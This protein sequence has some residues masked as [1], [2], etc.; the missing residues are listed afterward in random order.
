MRSR[1][2]AIVLAG[3]VW[4]AGA[5]Q[6][7][8]ASGDVGTAA[9]RVALT[10]EKP[11]AALFSIDEIVRFLEAAKQAEAI[12]DPL[13]RCLSYPDPPGSHWSPA[14]THAYCMYHMQEFMGFTEMK[15]LVEN[16]HAAELDRYMQNALQQQQTR[17]ESAGL[18]DHI[19]FGNFSDS[20]KETRALIDAWKR[21][22]PKSAFAY[23]A[24]GSSYL[25]MAWRAR[26][27]MAV[28]DTPK[29][30]FV[31]MDKWLALGKADLG[32]A[33]RLNPRIAFAY[34][35][36]ID[37]AMLTGDAAAASDAANRG[38][39]VEPAN[40]AIYAQM[41]WM[42]EPKW[43]GSIE[44][45]SL[46]VRH[47]QA[48]ASKNGLLKLLLPLPAAYVADLTD[49]NCE[50]HTDLGSY[51]MVLDDMPAG[52]ILSGV[53]AVTNKRH[54]VNL[55]VIYQSE[56]L[57]FSPWASRVRL[58]RAPY[59]AAFREKP[60][61]LE[62]MAELSGKLNKDASTLEEF[63]IAYVM[64]GE[65]K[66]AENDYL[67]II[68]SDPANY[69]ARYKLGELYGDGLN[70]WDKSWAMADQLIKDAP[71]NANGWLLRALV[72]LN[73]QRSG[74]K[75][76]MQYLDKHFADDPDIQARVRFMLE[77]AAQKGKESISRPG[78]VH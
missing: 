32:E 68:A 19:Y 48:H 58:L 78:Q 10:Q 35:V 57:R 56:V 7:S 39:A 64:M 37:M 40:Y 61:A 13:Q 16:G 46:I 55:A 14:A 52:E 4:V 65:P 43:G 6:I 24:S 34:T 31:A 1:I 29:E 26:G 17:P 2:Q 18:L 73:Q 60:W 21:Q 44:E 22:S 62:E 45:M 72:Q 12:K 53:A 49:C 5:I 30:N 25:R 38:L 20:S 27:Q 23:V 42:A 75:D 9:D 28:S 69:D 54:A 66:L 33:I 3:I 8:L 74:L 77:V 71:N 70:Q 63:A 50:G 11:K 47:A 51:R 36:L 67:Q 76:T 15:S 41:V 59:L